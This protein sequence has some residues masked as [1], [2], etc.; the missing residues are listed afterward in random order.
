M[1]T[2]TLVQPYFLPGLA[3]AEAQETVLTFGTAAEPLIMHAPI[4]T[5]AALATVS[6][7]L[8]EA[9]EATLADRPVAEIVGVIDR[10]VQHWLDPLYPY[11]QQAE[12]LL[13]TITH[14]SLPM[15]RHGLDTLLQALRQDA[16]WRLLQAEFGDPGVLDTFRP[17]PHAGGFTRAYG[18]RLITH[19]FS[20]NVP[21]LSA[22]S[23]VCALLTKS[24]SLG[25]TA[26]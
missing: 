19:I 3:L 6:Q 22:W 4:L 2:A 16:L 12:E 21:A 25:K 18:P 17:R 5:P 24:A 1:M 11:R 15:I 20:G 8:L 10:V 23:L 14:Y 7:Q 9:Q 13:P 26:S